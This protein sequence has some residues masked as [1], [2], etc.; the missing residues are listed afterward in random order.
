MTTEILI[1]TVVAVETQAAS[2]EDALD[3]DWYHTIELAPGLVTPGWFDTREVARELPIPETL[4]GMRC[5]D[6][7]TFDGFWAFEMERR[8]A[9]EVVAID[10][11]DLVGADWPPNTDPET[12]G[13]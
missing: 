11:L 3:R 5:L 6:V 10:L 7:A 9:E 4:A 13:A 1:G 12:I 8:G 2:L